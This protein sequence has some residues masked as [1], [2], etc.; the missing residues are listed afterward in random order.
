MIEVGDLVKISRTS[1]GDAGKHGVV[2]EIGYATATRAADPPP[3]Y[4]ILLVG[5]TETKNF[6]MWE[7]T[8]RENR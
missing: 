6:L 1:D 3:W 2:I 8:K 7:V 5:E 4:D